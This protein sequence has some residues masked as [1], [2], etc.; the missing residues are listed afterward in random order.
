MAK[1]VSKKRKVK[2]FISN[3]KKFY[4]DSFEYLIE[5]KNFIFVSI[6]VFIFFVLLGFFLPVPDSIRIMILQFIEELIS[7]TEGL[8]QMGLIKFIF[9]NNVQSSFFGMFFGIV[10]GIFPMMVAI[11]NGYLLGVVSLMAIESE[12]F[13]VLWR[14]FPHGIFELPAVF[15]SIGMGLRLGALFFEKDKLKNFKRYFLKSLLTFVLIII[16]LLVIAAII[17]GSLMYLMK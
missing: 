4:R 13:F 12:G 1:G 9:L 14:L 6:G 5:C 11:I 10:F 7:K 15:I 16:P 8:S 2:S 17:E 3:L